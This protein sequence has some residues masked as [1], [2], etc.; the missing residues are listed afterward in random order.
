MWFDGDVGVACFAVHT[1]GYFA[2]WFPS[3]KD[4]KKCD[5]IVLFNLSRKLHSGMDGIEA[6]IKGDGRVRSCAIPQTRAAILNK[7]PNV[8]HV[9][10]YETGNGSVPL[11]SHLD[12]FVHGIDHPNLA[13]RHHEREPNGSRIITGV[14][15]VV[16]KKIGRGEA[17]I[18]EVNY[19]VRRQLSAT[20]EC[21]VIS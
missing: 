11:T 6:V 7:T 13:D 12:G 14:V 18:N 2:I 21:R 3:E 20:V 16:V 1:C 17:K 19:F 4:V 8:V 15:A 5:G 9:D 10:G